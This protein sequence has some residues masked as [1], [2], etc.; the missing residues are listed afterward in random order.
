VCLPLSLGL[1]Q[2]NAECESLEFGNFLKFYY[3]S[4]LSQYRATSPRGGR[5]AAAGPLRKDDASREAASE[6]RR[7]CDKMLLL[8]LIAALE[9]IGPE[10]LIPLSLLEHVVDCGEDRGGDG[11][12]GLAG[13]APRPDLVELG[14]QVVVLLAHRRPGTQGERT[15]SQ[16]HFAE[17]ALTEYS[18]VRSTRAR[19]PTSCRNPWA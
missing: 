1:R 17:D 4:P 12:D 13:T 6:S 15:M 3:N 16:K 9:V 8:V 7:S 11:Y 5:P 14:A 19:S 10:L 2:K 18:A